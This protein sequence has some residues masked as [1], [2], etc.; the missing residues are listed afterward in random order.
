MLVRTLLT[1]LYYALHRNTLSHERRETRVIA[2]LIPRPAIGLRSHPGDA[3]AR[4]RCLT[5]RSLERFHVL[6]FS[7][8][9]H[10]RR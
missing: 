1:V 2:H 9:Y 3:E 7:Y 6:L 5:R 8:H 10:V 4:L